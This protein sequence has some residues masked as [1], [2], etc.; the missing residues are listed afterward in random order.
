MKIKCRVLT[1]P[2]ASGKTELAM[3]LAREMGWVIFCMDS[4]QVYKKLD[5]GTAKPTAE[6]RRKVPHFML[7]LCEPDESFSVAMYREQAEKLVS[8]L[9]EKEGREV[10]F[11]G[12]T[13]LYLQ[14]M[15]YPFE[16]GAVPGDEKRR[17]ELRMIGN[18]PNGK[19]RLRE[20]LLSLDPEAAEKISFNDIRRTIRAIEVTEK[21]GIRFSQQ[22]R[23]R[24]EEKFEWKILSTSMPRELLYGRI[25]RR[26]TEMIGKG[27]K[28]EVEGLLSSGVP[29]NAQCMSGL[30]YKEM[31]PCVKGKS[32]RGETIEAIQT[33][34]R[35][36]AK[37]Q[38]TFLRRLEQVQYVDVTEKDVYQHIREILL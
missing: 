11:V 14:A 16:M 24:K 34:T 36:Y 4:M 23:R 19:Q 1:G 3:R 22:P 5:I 26:V 17:E 35:H 10:L 38:M 15:V 32:S 6:D 31:I 25:N 9:W 29:E 13:G 30:G 21:T 7:D 2:T 28:E 20:M 27:L 12:G 18:T 33:G 8:D 37:R